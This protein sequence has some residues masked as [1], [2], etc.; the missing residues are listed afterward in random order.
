MIDNSE[1]CTNLGTRILTSV[2]TEIQFTICSVNFSD[3]LRGDPDVW[4]DLYTFTFGPTDYINPSV[5]PS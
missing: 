5:L 1:K 2:I 4:A 3:N